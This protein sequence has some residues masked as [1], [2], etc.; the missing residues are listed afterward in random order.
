MTLKP[1]EILLLC[2]YISV[3]NINRSN[4]DFIRKI[5]TAKYTSMAHCHIKIEK[6]AGLELLISKE[7]EIDV[8]F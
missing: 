8:D 1:I 5:K 4:E 7:H 2:N 6:I 3:L